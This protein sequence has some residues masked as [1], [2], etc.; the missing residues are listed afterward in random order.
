MM[1]PH[2]VLVR[3]ALAVILF[4]VITHTRADPDLWGH[5][6]FGKDIVTGGSIPDEDAYSFTSGSTWI[7]HE[8]LAE[9]VMYLAYAIGGGPGLVVL[10][11]SIMLLAMALVWSGLKRQQV[12]PATRD[13]LIA[14]A[15]VGTFPQ[16]NHVRPQIF[17]IVAFALLLWILVRGGPLQ[18]LLLLPLVFA[19]WV[20]FH[21][22]WIVGGG[23][24]AIWAALTLPASVSREE[25][26]TVFLAGAMSLVGTL[27]NPYG[28][29]MWLFL[30]NTVGFGRAE[31]T[32]WQPIYRLGA[33]FV[34]LWAVVALVA[35]AG[36]LHSWR[37]HQWELRR[38]GV[39]V[40]L[41]L[42][43][44]QVS[45]LLPFFTIA[46]VLLLG[47]DVA[48]GLSL[49]RT[50]A[51]AARQQRTLATTAAIVI[52]GALIV[53]GSVASAGNLACVRMAEDHSE[54]E[55]VALVKQRQLRGRLAVWFDWGEYA[56]WHFA[57]LL[58]VSID[59][60]RETVYTDRVIDEHLNFYYVPSSRA[61][62]LDQTRPDYIWLRAD[63]PVV[64]SLLADGW[65]PLYRGPHSIWLSRDAMANVGPDPSVTVSEIGRRCFPG[66]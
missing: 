30:S 63:L 44:L 8:W 59:G 37:S 12:D 49:W 27:A 9:C 48:A 28:W 3:T 19:A 58:R 35:L 55:V 24:L 15:V 6:L 39:V 11:V 29:H 33:G 53:G 42:G 61:A 26:V 34:A 16:A 4:A 18:R 21:G 60:R 46:V 13:L 17:S 20:N 47:R 52:A 41:G 31:I 56:I 14:L 51:P 36:A 5:V 66:P 10:K 65:Q 54:P 43:S 57:P 23:I 50:S 38:L 32:D 7:N 45:R 22:G 25:K 1:P 40:V 2:R 62:F 64:P